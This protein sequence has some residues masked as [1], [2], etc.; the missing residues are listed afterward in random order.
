MTTATNDDL[1]TLSYPSD[2]VA[3]ITLNRPDRMNA[4]SFALV[5]QLHDTL[6]RVGRDNSCRV[7]ILTGAGRGFCSGLDLTNIEGSSTSAGTSGRAPAC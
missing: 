6:D 5:D 1:A 7:A 3:L 2:G 4:L